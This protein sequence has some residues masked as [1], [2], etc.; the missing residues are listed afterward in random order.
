MRKRQNISLNALRAFEAAGRLGRISHAADE[1]AVTHGAVSR[2][3]GALE[4]ALGVQLIEGSRR[5]PKLTSAGM[6]LLPALTAAFDD[7]D[8]AL[9]R[10]MQVE[11]TTIDVACLSTFAIRWLIPR[12]HHFK[13]LHPDADVR[14]STDE[15]KIAGMGSQYDLVIT[16]LE[17]GARLGSGDMELFEERLGLIH[18]PA[19]GSELASPLPRLATRTRPNAWREWSAASGIGFDDGKAALEYEHYYFTLEAALGGLGTCVAPLH[20]VED[21]VNAGRLIAPHGFVRSGYRYVARLKNDAR[22]KAK[23]FRNWLK[24][25]ASGKA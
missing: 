4:A 17:E 15:E 9:S 19:V 16:V 24:D 25:E 14:L 8:A 18:A 7:I 2:Q 1:L 20:L 3:V 10:V 21:A 13:A 12:L 23:T 6:D 11:Q 22:P 5:E